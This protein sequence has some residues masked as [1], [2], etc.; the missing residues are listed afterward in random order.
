M[1]RKLEEK[2]KDIQNF[3]PPCS[4]RKLREFLGL[5][6]FYRRFIPSC[7]DILQPLT[8]I[9][10]DKS[11]NKKIELSHDQLASFDS[12][13]SSLAKAALL[14]HPQA[15]APLC[16]VTD[17]SNAA[18][19]AVLQQSDNGVMTPISF[20]QNVYTLQR[21]DIAHLVANCWLSI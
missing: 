4:L 10:V 17:A 15:G 6:N 14:A 3:P 19:G 13:K 18:V 11:K 2:V 7:A 16:L 5:V 12:I 20:F 1:Q 8:D 21:P 9:L